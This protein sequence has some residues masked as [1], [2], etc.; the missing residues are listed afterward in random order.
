VRSIIDSFTLAQ[1]NA[2][3]INE[4]IYYTLLWWS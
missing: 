2:E 1:L 3:G 4:A